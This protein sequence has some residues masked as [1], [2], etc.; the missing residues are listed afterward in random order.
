MSKFDINTSFKRLRNRYRLV[1]M[2]DDTYEEVATFRLNRLSVY[3]AVSTIFILLIG[4]TVALLWFT[5][6][7]QLTPGYK[8]GYGVDAKYKK[9]KIESD[10]VFKVALQQSNY[11]NNIKMLLQEKQPTTILDSTILKIIPEIEPSK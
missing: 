11:I 5:P 8:Q 1:V 9:L 2:N 3:I 7:K 4:A 10:S 6:L